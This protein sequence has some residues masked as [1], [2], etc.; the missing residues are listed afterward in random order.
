MIFYSQKKVMESAY[1]GS[2]EPYLEISYLGYEIKGLSMNF[3]APFG[4]VCSQMW[5]L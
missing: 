1:L 2:W 4:A 3:V 5:D